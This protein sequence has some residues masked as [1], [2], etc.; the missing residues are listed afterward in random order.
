MAGG[1]GE[2]RGEVLRSQVVV[3]ERATLTRVEEE[4][5]GGVADV[6]IVCWLV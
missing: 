2:K 3:E 5:N 4:E 6:Y 1:V